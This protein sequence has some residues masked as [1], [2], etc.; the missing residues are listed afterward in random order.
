LSL[1]VLLFVSR[2]DLLCLAVDLSP[3][4]RK[5]GISTDTGH[6]VITTSALERSLYFAAPGKILNIALK[7]SQTMLQHPVQC[8]HRLHRNLMP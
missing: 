1:P 6:S 3:I 7:I 2:R 5:N 8:L 4:Q